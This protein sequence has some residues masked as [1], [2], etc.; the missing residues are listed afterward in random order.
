[1]IVLSKGKKVFDG[2]PGL[3][4]SVADGKTWDEDQG[5]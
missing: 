2:E 4:A 3:L 1:V 5:G